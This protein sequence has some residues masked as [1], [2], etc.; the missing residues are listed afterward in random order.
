MRIKSLDM[1]SVSL[2]GLAFIAIVYYL[3]VVAP[4]LSKK[5]KLEEYI[6][7]KRRM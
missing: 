1:I 5:T 3:L 2:A 6:G 4:A 7:R